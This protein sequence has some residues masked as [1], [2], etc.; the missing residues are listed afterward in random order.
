MV[1][2]WQS[3][4]I[5]LVLPA[6]NNRLTRA[7]CCYFAYDPLLAVLNLTWYGAPYDLIVVALGVEYVYVADY[8]TTSAPGVKHV[9]AIEACS[10]V[11]C[12]H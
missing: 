2:F 10:N 6:S 4:V 8:V 12:D 11:I 5:H 9:K 7:Q 1:R 3:S